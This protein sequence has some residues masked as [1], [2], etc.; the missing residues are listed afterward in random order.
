MKAARMNQGKPEFD[1]L[2]DFPIA[3]E[4]FCRVKELGAVKYARDNWKLGGKPDSEY[5]A[6]ALR[7]MM[8]HRQGELY[9]EDTGCLHLAHAM[10][11]M[12]ALIE[13]NVKETH[14]KDVFAMMRQHWEAKKAENAKRSMANAVAKAPLYEGPHTD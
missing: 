11:N 1:F 13:L 9:A 12:A 7:H 4:A 2:L 6:A 5:L 10:W 8:A 3:M 14:D